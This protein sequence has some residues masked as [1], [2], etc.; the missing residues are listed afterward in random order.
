MTTADT[1][2]PPIAAKPRTHMSRRRRIN[3]A[4][5]VCTLLVMF[6]IL[7]F[8][9]VKDETLTVDVQYHDQSRIAVYV[10]GRTLAFENLSQPNTAPAFFSR[11]TSVAK[12]THTIEVVEE[13]SGTIGFVTVDVY[14]TLYVVANIVD[15]RI[16]FRVTS[17]S[18]SFQ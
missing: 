11:S 2:S 13:I 18:P 7:A 14:G 16:D 5:G 8:L 12:G 4:F 10:D 3:F 1:G 6:S 9:W 17:T 15:G